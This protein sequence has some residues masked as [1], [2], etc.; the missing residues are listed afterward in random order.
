MI[1]DLNYLIDFVQKISWI[2][3]TVFCFFFGF[4]AVRWI[5]NTFFPERSVTLN[6]YH[7]DK[8]IASYEIDLRS[9]ETLVSQLR[10]TKNDKGGRNDS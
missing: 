6:R 9:A 8:L 7:E 3:F 2:P 4:A 10:K 1:A 5:G